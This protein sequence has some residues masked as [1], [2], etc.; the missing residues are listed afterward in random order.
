MANYPENGKL[1]YKWL[2]GMVGN[3]IDPF[4]GGRTG[5]GSTVF[6]VVIYHLR[7][8]GLLREEKIE[9]DSHQLDADAI[10]KEKAE[11]EAYWQ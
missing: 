5:D 3:E 7:H 4:T 6:G 1:S 11:A 9:F 10:Q 2:E 8:L